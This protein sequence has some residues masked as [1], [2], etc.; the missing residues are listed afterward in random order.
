M[1]SKAKNFREEITEM[2][3]FGEKSFENLCSSVQKARNAEPARFLYSL[4]IPGI[5]GLPMQ[6]PDRPAL[7]EQLGCD[8]ES[9]TKDRTDDDRWDRRRDGRSLY[10]IFC[11]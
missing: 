10:E 11:G 3:G 6:R 1:S 5:G 8:P 7:Q 9:G 2:E 4:G